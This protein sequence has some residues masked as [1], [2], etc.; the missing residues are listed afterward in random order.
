MTERAGV[1]AAV[2]SSA[3]GIAAAATR[4]AIPCTD[5]IRLA[6]GVWMASTSPRPAH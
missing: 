2:L 3:F 4:F 5:P 6:G 1:L